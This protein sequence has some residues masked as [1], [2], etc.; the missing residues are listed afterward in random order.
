MELAVMSKT[1]YSIGLTLRTGSTYLNGLPRPQE[2]FVSIVRAGPGWQS[3]CVENPFGTQRYLD[4]LLAFTKIFM[5]RRPAAACI[6]HQK[7]RRPAVFH[8]LYRVPWFTFGKEISQKTGREMEAYFLSFQL[9]KCSSV[10][11]VIGT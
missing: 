7:P 8:R 10:E 4:L 11:S 2:Y 1:L 5:K 9:P 3:G 6:D